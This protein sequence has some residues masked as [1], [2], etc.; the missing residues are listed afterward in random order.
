MKVVYT[1]LS[2]SWLLVTVLVGHALVLLSLQG[3]QHWI[4]IHHGTDPA[5]LSRLRWTLVFKVLTLLFS[6]AL[7]NIKNRCK[8][9]FSTGR[10]SLLLLPLGSAHRTACVMPADT[11]LRVWLTIFS[12]WNWMLRYRLCF[13]YCLVVW[14]WCR[15]PITFISELGRLMIACRQLRVGRHRQFGYW[16]TV[17]STVIPISVLV[18]GLL[19]MAH[20]VAWVD[21]RWRYPD[22]LI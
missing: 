5:V 15:R 6:T 17:R 3:L 20:S 12:I 13:L 11:S 2:T 16:H 10:R 19:Q 14:M 4:L 18:I 8:L 7:V 9:F 21:C 1:L 22:C